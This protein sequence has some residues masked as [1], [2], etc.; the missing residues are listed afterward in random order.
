MQTTHYLFI[1]CVEK[2]SAC[3]GRFPKNAPYKK[4]NEKNRSLFDYDYIKLS[5]Y[6]TASI[7]SL[8]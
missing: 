7:A 3:R 5:A 8:Q 6:R 1:L 2:M 4:A